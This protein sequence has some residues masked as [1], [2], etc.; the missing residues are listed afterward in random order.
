MKLSDFLEV[1]SYLFDTEAGSYT[2][3]SLEGLK[4]GYLGWST[5]TGDAQRLLVGYT[6]PSNE[7]EKQIQENFFLADKKK[8]VKWVSVAPVSLAGTFSITYTSAFDNLIKDSKSRQMEILKGIFNQ[9]K[10]YSEALGLKQKNHI[11]VVFFRMMLDPVPYSV[12]SDL[13]CKD[14]EDIMNV[15]TTDTHS[16]LS[17]LLS[18]DKRFVPGKDLDLAANFSW[19][20]EK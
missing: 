9:A 16:L 4:I 8:A 11:A 20:F 2:I 7:I 10:D 1:Y 13:S 15:L 6:K 19:L 12:I 3:N 14:V 5:S 17:T 18:E